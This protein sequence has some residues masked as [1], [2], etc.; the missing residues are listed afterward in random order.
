MLFDRT[1]GK[2]SPYTAN[3]P[4]NQ[5]EVWENASFLN[6]NP[7]PRPSATPSLWT[8]E[9]ERAVFG[10]PSPAPPEMEDKSADEDL[11]RAWAALTAKQRARLRADERNWIRH[12]NSLPM[13]ERNED[14][15]KR[16]NYLWSLSGKDS[17]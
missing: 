4:E 15:R 5:E 10:T 17:N 3:H 16:A 14:T 12:N 11:N 1:T 2:Y 13:K 9:D 6:I 7:T 8:E